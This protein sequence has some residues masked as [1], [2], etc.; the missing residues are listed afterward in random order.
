MLCSSSALKVILKKLHMGEIRDM[1][2]LVAKEKGADLAL[3][4]SLK[5]FVIYSA[6]YF[7]I[8]QDVLTR[9]NATTKV[10]YIQIGKRDSFWI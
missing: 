5:D 3:N 8:T 6:D 4:K 9:L 2:T 1:T 10:G 7:D